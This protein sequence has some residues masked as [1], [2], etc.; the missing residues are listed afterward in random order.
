MT[1]SPNDETLA[2]TTPYGEEG[3]PS[4][5]EEHTFQAGDAL[6]D[7]YRIVRFISRGGM[8][9]VYE[10]EDRELRTRVA[11]KTIRPEIAADPSMM[12]RFRREIHLAHRITHP[13]V[14]R[15]YDIGFHRESGKSPVAFLTMELLD[16]ETLAARVAHGGR[17]KTD[18]ALP[19]VAQM[20][21]ALDAA[22]AAGIVHRDFKSG[23][24][25][26]VE[27]DQGPRAVVTDF[28]LAR[29]AA[30]TDAFTGASM[31]GTGGV[32]G[33]QLYMAP[34]QVE[35]AEVTGA[36]DVYA[37][38]VVMYE[39][40]TAKWPFV[41]DSAISTAVKRL[42]QPPPSPRSSV[43]DLD[44][45][46]E[47]AIL[48]CLERD[49][50]NRFATAGDAVRALAGES[51]R[52]GRSTRRAALAAIAA[53]VVLAGAVGYYLSRR[54]TPSGSIRSRR[55]VAV[56]GFKNLSGRPDA[57]WL[58]TALSEMLTTELSAGETLRT[59]PGETVA[60]LKV[61]L[62]LPDSDSY[63]KDT[64]AKIRGNIDAGYVVLGSYLAV[65]GAPLRVD[66]KL[67]DAAAGETIAAVSDSG[68]EA[69]IADLVSRVAAR[70]REKLG[71][72]SVSATQAAAIR[73]SLP[74][75]PEGAR[76]YA[77]GLSKL[78]LFDYVAAR[79]LLEKAVAADPAHALSRAA[80][81]ETYMS[82]GDEP[83]AQAS[84]RR[85][86]ELSSG[87]SREDR[88]WIEGRSRETTHEWDAAVAAYRSLFFS[89]P[90][91][92]EYGLRLLSAQNWTPSAKADRLKTIAA[93]RRLPPPSGDDPRIDLAE[94]EALF[95]AGEYKRAAETA[96][97][98]ESRAHERGARL[99]E[100]AALVYAAGAALQMGET[101]KSM[102]MSE[103][104]RRTYVEV[105][106]RLNEVKTIQ[107][108]ELCLQAQGRLAEARKTVEQH[109]AILREM[110]A[111]T[112]LPAA[113]VN[114]SFIASQQGD[115]A[116]A[117]RAAEESIEGFRAN[118]LKIGEVY[119]GGNLADALVRE[120]RL[121]EA[122]TLAEPFLGIARE[123]GDSNG[124]GMAQSGQSWLSYLRGDVAGAQ[125]ALE[126]ALAI[127][128]KSEARTDVASSLAWRAEL[129]RQ[130]DRLPEARKD[131]EEAIRIQQGTGDAGRLA[132]MR[133]ALSRLSIEEGRPADAIAPIRE[134]REIFRTQGRLSDEIDAD[135]GLAE[136]QLALGRPMEA[137]AE[138][139]AATAALERSADRM[140]RIQTQIAAGRVRAA[141]GDE[142]GAIRDLEKTLA[143]VDRIGVF[144]FE[145]DARLAL[146][147]IESKSGRAAAGRARLESLERDAKAKGFLLVARK[148]SSSRG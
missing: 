4:S 63:A 75:S 117:R 1:D 83:K 123:A 39:M 23:N 136:A 35:G 6:A 62:A 130:S 54:A 57:A 18:E 43:P 72:G 89:A 41:G 44:R 31:T 96:A 32:A 105:G 78:R 141:E 14:C 138:I 143:D 144:P 69:Q 51:V 20:A 33:T 24:V 135:T 120:G 70:L 126:E 28:G 128:R 125:T 56:L 21:A 38:G 121:A 26:L 116:A 79:E 40:V 124:I 81:A 118:R 127:A 95:Q 19:I 103:R 52:S 119:A 61:S 91:N 5:V 15:V 145:L 106:D 42:K 48:R 8:G 47:S 88:L 80:L 9:E 112:W 17:L 137:R 2:A 98:A 55:S 114:L 25:V 104:A 29:A 11:L 71:A 147:Q 122:V 65:A 10:A 100:T 86:V 27:S 64:L 50:A 133:V 46:W 7:R 30:G 97:R 102:E 3:P 113:L 82:L 140:A 16:G 58:S 90:D 60:R 101:D 109:I 74:S 94:I 85:A 132:Q 134:A 13:N 107:G 53:V 59:I 67:Q 92:L 68:T 36:A 22:H 139:A 146:G 76:L 34:E 87:L 37:L 108:I 142:A 129:L 45:R 110:G 111:A 93:L 148:A 49:P 99:V 66:L 84:E 73:A 77:E 131:V 12:E 115:V